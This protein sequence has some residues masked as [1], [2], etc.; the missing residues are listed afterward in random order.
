MPTNTLRDRQTADSALQATA[1]KGS[2]RLIAIQLYFVVKKRKQIIT[3][4]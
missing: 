2:G 1:A 3:Q 4:Q